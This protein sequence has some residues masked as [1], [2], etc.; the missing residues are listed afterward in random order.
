[1]A[2]TRGQAKA[3]KLKDQT[4]LKATIGI[5]IGIFLLG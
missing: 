4:T 2:M 5:S 3:K 1:M